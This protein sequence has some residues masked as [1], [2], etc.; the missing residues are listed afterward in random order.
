MLKVKDLNNGNLG[1]IEHE[2][3]T[4]IDQIVDRLDIYWDDYNIKFFDSFKDFYI[5]INAA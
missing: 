1:E 3:F 4:D 2:E 5:S